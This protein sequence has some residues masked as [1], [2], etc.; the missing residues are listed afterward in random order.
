MNDWTDHPGKI[1][2]WEA[3][4][5]DPRFQGSHYYSAAAGTMG[6][7]I[8]KGFFGLTLTGDGLTVS[9]RLGLYDGNVRVYQ[10]ATDRYAAYHYD[11]DQLVT[12]IDYG[13]NTAEPVYFR[14]LKLRS[15]Q[16]QA[17]TID[18]QPVEFTLETLGNDTYLA[19]NGPS[20]QHRIAILKGQAADPTTANPAVVAENASNSAGSVATLSIERVG[21]PQTL[22]TTAQTTGSM[23][24]EGGEIEAAEAKPAARDLTTD[25]LTRIEAIVSQNWRQ[26]EIIFSRD[27]WLDKLDLLAYDSAF[28]VI[29]PALILIIMLAARRP[30]RR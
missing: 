26:A 4:N 22:E 13:T 14:I 7:A 5:G 16:V 3:A 2:E 28:R 21:S 20:G 24:D 19:F 10:A 27:Y 29:F 25:P 8:I 18:D 23:L 12:H 11:W 15:E 9:P 17:I 1:I 30:A 6:S